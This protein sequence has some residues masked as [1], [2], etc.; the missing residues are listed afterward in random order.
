L[1]FLPLQKSENQKM[2]RLQKTFENAKLGNF[3]VFVCY[4]TGGYPL[5]S[6]VKTML[7]LQE[8]GCDVLEIG[9]PFSDPI[10]DGKVIQK[11][12]FEALKTG[13]TLQMCLQ[14]V[15]E[16]R[17]QGLVIPVVLMGY[18]N[19]FLNYGTNLMK[20]CFD[21][22]VDGFIVVDLPA[23]EAVLFRGNAIDWGYLRC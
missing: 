16:A 21:A 20:D 9:I 5:N 23:E 7:S 15:R 2:S 4:L 17:E 6:T 1:P 13:V 8:N 3:T 12:S 19:P 10:A 18:Y 22:G 14:F 11:S